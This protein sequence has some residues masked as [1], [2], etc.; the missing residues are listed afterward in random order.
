MRVLIIEDEPLLA[1]QLKKMIS[2]MEPA[3]ETVAITHTIAESVRLLQQPP[4]PE[5]ILMDIELADGQ[6]FDI[7][8]QVQ[9]GSSV[10]F[11]TAYD[12]YAIKAF[13]LNGI[14]YLLKPV[15]KEELKAAL[16]KFHQVQQ[17]QDISG[18]I[19]ALFHEIQKLQQQSRGYR[20]RF[21]IKSG[22]KMISVDVQDIAYIISENAFSYLHT[23][24]QKY[25]VDYTLDE[26]ENMLSPKQYFRANRK[27]ILN[28]KSVVAI[29]PWFNQ[30]LIVEVK[31]ATAEN[32][33]ISREKANR[34]KSWLGE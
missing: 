29:R 28:S 23:Q 5:L 20:E 15:N 1:G 32:I 22:T 7:F 18:S 34:F 33:I 30:K 4:Q 19:Q 8:Q 17:R 21:L 9:I 13:R 12:E 31:P 6:S 24:N 16:N 11:I 26:L 2:E 10:I 3:V 14:D 27:C 25:I